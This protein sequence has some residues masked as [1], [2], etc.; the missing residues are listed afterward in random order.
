MEGVLPRRDSPPNLLLPPVLEGL[1]LPPVPHGL[2]PAG[3]GGHRP[4]H[5][6]QVSPEPET[7]MLHSWL[8][9][10]AQLAGWLAGWLAATVGSLSPVWLSRILRPWMAI[11]DDGWVV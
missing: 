11:W 2:P 7:R 6:A 3:N 9:Y 1:T 5:Q 10:L 8:E 4:V